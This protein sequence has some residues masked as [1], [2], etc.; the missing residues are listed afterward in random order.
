MS[1]KLNVQVNTL[2]ISAESVQ[3]MKTEPEGLL[4]N[5]LRN[6]HVYNR[7]AAIMMRRH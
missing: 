1:E 2:N 6:N 3:A 4:N 5:W 7:L